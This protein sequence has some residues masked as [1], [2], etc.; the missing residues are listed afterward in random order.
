MIMTDD[1]WSPY[2]CLDDAKK[3]DEVRDALRRGDLG[4][5]G[6]MGRVFELTPIVV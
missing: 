2:L 5:A 3:L 4:T 1:G 6:R